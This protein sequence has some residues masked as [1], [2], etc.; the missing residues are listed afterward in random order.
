MMQT[1]IT[2]QNAMGDANNDSKDG[3]PTEAMWKNVHKRKGQR[4]NE[5]YHKLG[6]EPTPHKIHTKHAMVQNVI[7]ND[8]E[9]NKEVLMQKTQRESLQRRI[10]EDV[11]TKQ[12]TGN[13]STQRGTEDINTHSNSL[14]L[15]R[16][17]R[18]SKLSN[19]KSGER[20]SR[21]TSITRR[22]CKKVDVTTIE[23]MRKKL[24]S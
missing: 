2:V 7:Y 21:K 10:T 18:N 20:T 14:Q 19:S 13:A 8:E 5:L 24:N 15:G 17:D 22:I 6:L 11:S 9:E 12:G 23:K 3:L 16:K 1:P 4:K